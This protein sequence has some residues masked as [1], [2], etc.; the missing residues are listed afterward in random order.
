AVTHKAKRK[1]KR[2]AKSKSQT[3]PL[4]DVGLKQGDSR[5]SK[6]EKKQEAFAGFW[7]AYPRRVAKEAARR[8]FAAAVEG[9]TDAST[10]VDGARRYAI[11]RNGKEPRYTKPPEPSLLG[12][13]LRE[14]T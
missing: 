6:E 11:E 12:R 8:A 5:A 13:C 2:K 7:A 10:I 14:D 4:D 1:A 3:R 9:G